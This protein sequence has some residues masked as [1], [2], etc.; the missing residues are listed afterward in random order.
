MGKCCFSSSPYGLHDFHAIAFAQ[1]VAFVQA[2]GHDLAIDFHRDAA[3]GI[4]GIGEKGGNCGG[5]RALARDAIQ[6][7][8]HPPILTRIKREDARDA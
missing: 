2:A 7:D 8:L 1:C 5:W 4:A 6:D 3:S